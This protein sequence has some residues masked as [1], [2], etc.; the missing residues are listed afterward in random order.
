M[1]ILGVDYGQKRIG[2]AI[3]DETEMLA[4]SLNYLPGA[5]LDKAARSVVDIAESQGAGKI[6]V[7]VPSNLRGNDT[8]QTERTRQFIAKLGDISP[9]PVECWDE[10]L[11]SA[12]AER[13]LLEGGVR[14]RQR[15]EKIDQL[16]AQL[17]LQSYLDAHTQL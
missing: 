14:R 4:T 5:G 7:G 3:S 6:V 15:R 1:R 10:R 9:L 2:L 16:A 17:L 8:P 13:A 12:Q 11:T